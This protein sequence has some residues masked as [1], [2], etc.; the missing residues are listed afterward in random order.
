MSR[1]LGSCAQK[2]M[3]K[4]CKIKKIIHGLFFFNFV[5]SIQLTV[6]M[7]CIKVCR[8]LDSN[9]GPLVSEATVPPTEP[10]S[11][12]QRLQNWNSITSGAI[13]AKSTT[14]LIKSCQRTIH[15]VIIFLFSLQSYIFKM[16]Q[17]RHPG[18]FFNYFRLFKHTT[19][20]EKYPSC[21]QSQD[22]NSHPHSPLP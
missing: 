8:W 19:K 1:R 18:L 7:T 14:L 12:P 16:G 20:C 4:G 11:L 6:K 21:R 17:P 15:W 10:Q 5:F 9:H 13:C 3:S 22:S 2:V